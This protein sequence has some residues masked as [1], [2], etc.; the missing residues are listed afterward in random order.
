MA[1]SQAAVLDLWRFSAGEP[2]VRGTTRL[3]FSAE[4]WVF[5]E[6]MRPSTK[7]SSVTLGFGGNLPNWVVADFKLHVAEMWWSGIGFG[8]F[9]GLRT[10]LVWL[11]RALP[12][13]RGPPTALGPHEARLLRDCLLG[14]TPL[15]SPYT[16]GGVES[17]LNSFAAFLRRQYP[18]TPPD[19]TVRL[20]AEAKR[21]RAGVLAQSTEKFIPLE[22]LRDIITACVQDEEIF[23][24]A[25]LVHRPG[26]RLTGFGWAV[27]IEELRARAIKAQA[28]K[29]MVCTGRRVSAVCNLPIGVR[30]EPFAR[31]RVRPPDVPEADEPWGMWVYFVEQK[32]T[33]APEI[34]FCPYE[35][36]EI[37][38][39]AIARARRYAAELRERDSR[40]AEH[41]FV[42]SSR[43][44]PTAVDRDAVKRYLTHPRHGIVKRYGITRGEDAAELL[45]E[46]KTHNFRTT[47]ATLLWVGGMDLV[48]VARDLGHVVPRREGIPHPDMAGLH[49]VAG[50]MD[51]EAVAISALKAGAL[52]DTSD[53]NDAIRTR[54][55]RLERLNARRT[56]P[57]LQE[58]GTAI[59]LVR[60]GFC[61]LPAS[62]GPCLT[63]TECWEG[64]DPSDPE[65]SAG[66]EYLV[67]APHAV[68]AFEERERFLSAQVEW[69]GRDPAYAHYVG[70]ERRKLES[71]RRQLKTAHELRDRLDAEEGELG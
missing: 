34:V 59:Q 60:Y 2:L 51:V 15:L 17:Y 11:G 16:L 31:G 43:G 14:S 26:R 27:G 47:R 55:V 22:V 56:L 35:L 52:S 1:A 64:Q 49:Y 36:G 53:P 69:Y 18:D 39:D 10:A 6:F 32:I 40:F 44:R 20:P 58:S 3:E 19:F 65:G 30:T 61:R 50:T 41:L 37:A 63:A 68:P 70:Q 42:S 23:E 24:Q 71:L 62:R 9:Q 5:P 21:R 7:L 46:L 57:I 54:P 33:N 28:V 48:E 13:F 25:L 4:K 67:I 29:L 38:V 45:T 8:S 12:D 66:C